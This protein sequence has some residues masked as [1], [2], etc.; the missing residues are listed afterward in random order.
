VSPADA[1]HIGDSPSFDIAGAN[2]AGLTSVWINRKERVLKP[3]E[4]QPDYTIESLSELVGLLD[5]AR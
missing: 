2:A 4:A 5:S 3:H 1:W